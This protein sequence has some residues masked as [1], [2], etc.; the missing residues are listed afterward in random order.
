MTETPHL[1]SAEMSITGALRAIH[2][3]ILFAVCVDDSSVNAGIAKFY[4]WLYAQPLAHQP[5]FEAGCA[6]VGFALWIG[7]Y[8]VFDSVPRLRAFRFGGPARS[9]AQ[10]VPRWKSWVMGG[11]YYVAIWAYHIFKIKGPLDVEPPTIRRLGVELAL[12]V[13][14]YDVGEFVLHY[15]MHRVNAIKQLHKR[16][17]SQSKLTS[18]ET[19]NHSVPDA[20]QQILLNIL[21]QFLSPY[22]KK[23][24]LS[25]ILHNLLITYMLTEI[26][27]GYDGPWTMHRLW[28][29]F[30]GGAKRH[31]VHHRDG[32]VYFAEFFTVLDD[33][34]GTVEG[35][36]RVRTHAQ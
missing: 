19:L 11:G 18:P 12:G 10:D 28:P 25:R 27:A 22:G 24:S 13:V 33:L 23:H 5:T 1:G 2:L 35:K 31:E 30:F 3:A 20:A 9:A 17:H 36:A 4:R 16:H 14:A 21:V 8:K 6:I 34:C 26:H 29:G 7:L 15:S 32:E